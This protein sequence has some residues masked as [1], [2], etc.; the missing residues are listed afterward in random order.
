M[1]KNANLKKN[2]AFRK[3]RRFR[4]R[5]RWIVYNVLFWSGLAA[6]IWY[7][8]VV[9][10]FP[11]LIF[12]FAAFPILLWGDFMIGSIFRADYV[13]NWKSNYDNSFNFPNAP[14]NIGTFWWSVSDEDH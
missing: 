3:E 4:V 10:G 1:K 6:L 14:W 5:P 7:L 2:S 13:P 9:Q 8:H 12:L 11:T